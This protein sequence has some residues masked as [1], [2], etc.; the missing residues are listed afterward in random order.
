MGLNPSS[1][2][3]MTPSTDCSSE[4]GIDSYLEVACIAFTLALSL[5][6]VTRRNPSCFRTKWIH[7]V[8]GQNTKNLDVIV[9]VLGVINWWYLVMVEE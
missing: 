7:G 6:L 4:M 1:E 5:A 8:I 2:G 3:T 9:P